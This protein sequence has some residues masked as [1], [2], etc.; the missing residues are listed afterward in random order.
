[1]PSSQWVMRESSSAQNVSG[2]GNEPAWAFSTASLGNRAPGM[3]AAIC[4]A[5]TPLQ[6]GGHQW[7]AVDVAQ[8]FD[9]VDVI[10]ARLAIVTVEVVSTRLLI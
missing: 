6:G 8:G 7:N 10:L 4:G 3:V 1:M 5:G 9:L 2:M